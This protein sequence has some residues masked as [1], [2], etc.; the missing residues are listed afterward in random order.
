MWLGFHSDRARYAGFLSD[1]GRAVP[2]VL[3][4]PRANEAFGVAGIDAYAILKSS[5]K[6]TVAWKWIKFLL[7]KTQA[8]A[9]LLPPRSSQ[10]GSAS[11]KTLAGKE[12]AAIAASLPDRLLI[13]DSR[14]ASPALAGTVGAFLQA[15]ETVANG[16]ADAGDAL[17]EA[18]A[19]AEAAFVE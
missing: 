7:E 1:T 11:Y 3:P 18:Q 2:G 10:L 16:E 9:P 12:T 13:W 8:A 19:Q 5:Q 15:A 4:L 14:L 17:A 6:A